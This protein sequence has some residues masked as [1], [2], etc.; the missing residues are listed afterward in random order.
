MGIAEWLRKL[1]Q[2]LC[3]T[4]EGGMGREMGGRFRREGTYVHLRLIHVEV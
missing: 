3:I 2:G 4:L 1:K